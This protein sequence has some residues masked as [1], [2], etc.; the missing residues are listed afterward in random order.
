MKQ[1]SFI[2][3]GIV[4]SVA[5]VWAQGMV[6]ARYLG[7]AESSIA[8]AEG[9]EIANG[10]PA[11]LAVP[12]DFSFELHLIS[13]HAMAH[14]NSFSLNDYNRYFTTGDSLTSQDIDD[15]LGKIPTSGY[16]A[17]SLGEA[18]ALSFYFKSLLF[19]ITGMGSGKVTIPKAYFELPFRGN[20]NGKDYF[21]DSISGLGW[22]AASLNFSIGFPMTQ[23]FGGIFDFAS[24]GVTGKYITGI[25]YARILESSGQLIT[26]DDYISVEE[27]IRLL[28]S[29]G[30]K[31]FSFDMGAF[32]TFRQKWA[33][34]FHVIN[35]LGG[36]NWNKNNTIYFYQYQIDTIQ[37]NNLDSL[38]A[39]TQEVDTSYAA[40]GFHTGIPQVLNF[41]LAY[42][43][44]PNL[45]LTAAWMQGLNNEMNNTTRPYVAV[46]TEY[47]PLPLLPLR[48]GLGVGG[49]FGMVLGLGFGVDLKYF[50]LN[51]SY[52]N[53]NF[54]WFY[55]SKSMDLA[56][57]AQFRL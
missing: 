57:S 43:L 53:H 48:A 56:I 13:L 32:A 36:I 7:M 55:N 44:R 46:G 24:V 52:L 38:D 54:K 39:Y 34:S 35:L 40:G 27:S 26:E 45:T 20:A 4:L 25:E 12:H 9:A 3:F 31:G 14:N 16:Q 29:E 23:Y 8:I 37:A 6:D 28:T 5:L 51:L 17:F 21:F 30:G 11:L 1:F 2:F 18:K 49:R 22:A 15:L 47:R 42:Q 10:N 19:S 41:A 33:F 50:Q